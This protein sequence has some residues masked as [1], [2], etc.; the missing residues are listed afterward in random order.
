MVKKL[1]CIFIIFTLLYQDITYALTKSSSFHEKEFTHIYS[2]L[3]EVLL[4]IKNGNLQGLRKDGS[5]VWLDGGNFKIRFYEVGKATYTPHDDEDLIYED[6]IGGLRIEIYSKGLSQEDKDK[7]K[8]FL[9]NN[10]DIPLVARMVMEYIAGEK[11]LGSRIVRRSIEEETLSEFLSNNITID[12]DTIIR[13]VGIEPESDVRTAINDYL[14]IFRRR[15]ELKDKTLNAQ[16]VFLFR[17]LK[18]IEGEKIYKS[19]RKLLEL[20][21][22]KGRRIKLVSPDIMGWIVAKYEH[23]MPKDIDQQGLISFTWGDTIYINNN[24]RLCDLI[25]YILHEVVHLYGGKE[26]DARRVDRKIIAVLKGVVSLLRRIKVHDK[27]MKDLL[28]TIADVMEYELLGYELDLHTARLQ[29][30]VGGQAFLNHFHLSSINIIPYDES[31]I[32]AMTESVRG[33][34]RPERDPELFG[35]IENA[36]NRNNSEKI[37]MRLFWAFMKYIRRNL[38]E[39]QTPKEQTELIEP[40]YE[41]DILSYTITPEEAQRRL[42]EVVLNPNAPLFARINDAI[43]IDIFAESENLELGAVEKLLPVLQKEPIKALQILE[44]FRNRKSVELISS[45]LN[46]QDKKTRQMAAKCLFNIARALVSP[47]T[48][49]S[50]QTIK[51]MLDFINKPTIDIKDE[52]LNP[53]LQIVIVLSSIRCREAVPIF[54]DIIEKNKSKRIR[55]FVASALGSIGDTTI[56]SMIKERIWSK[57]DINSMWAT[58]TCIE[59]LPNDE[60]AE[61]IIET[62]FRTKNKGLTTHCLRALASVIKKRRISTKTVEPIIEE[63]MGVVTKHK[64]M[65]NLNFTLGRIA[66]IAIMEGKLEVFNNN[67][68]NKWLNYI[69]SNINGLI[70][71]ASGLIHDTLLNIDELKIHEDNPL[72]DVFN[73]ILNDLVGNWSELIRY[74]QRLRED[75]YRGKREYSDLIW[76]DIA[77]KFIHFSPNKEIYIGKLWFQRLCLEF[78]YRILL[79]TWDIGRIEDRDFIL[80]LMVLRTFFVPTQELPKGSIGA[81][82][83]VHGDYVV[84]DDKLFSD[85]LNI[86]GGVNTSWHEATHLLSAMGIADLSDI[87][88]LGASSHNYIEFY[89]LSEIFGLPDIEGIVDRLKN[90]EPIEEIVKDYIKIGLP[91]EYIYTIKALL[92]GMAVRDKSDSPGSAFF[93]VRNIKPEKV[94]KWNWEDVL[95]KLR[96]INNEIIDAYTIRGRQQILVHTY[97]DGARFSGYAMRLGV[98]TDFPEAVN[99]YI[100]LLVKHRLRPPQAEFVARLIA[101]FMKESSR[102]T[103]KIGKDIKDIPQGEINKWCRRFIIE[104]LKSLSI[105]M[106]NEIRLWSTYEEIEKLIERYLPDI[107]SQMTSHKIQ[108]E[109]KTLVLNAVK[110]NK[111]IFRAQKTGESK[112]TVFYITD[113]DGF[114]RP[115]SYT[116]ENGFFVIRVDF[117]KGEEI[118]SYIDPKNKK[119]RFINPE[120]KRIEID[121]ICRCLNIKLTKDNNMVIP[122][123]RYRKGISEVLKDLD[124]KKLKKYIIP[125][126][127]ISIVESIS[128]IT[129]YPEYGLVGIMGIIA[130]IIAFRFIKK[131]GILYEDTETRLTKQQRRKM[132]LSKAT[133]KEIRGFIKALSRGELL[134]RTGDVFLISDL[135]RLFL[136]HS[137]EDLVGILRK[138]FNL[139]KKAAS[140]IVNYIFKILEYKQEIT[141]MDLENMVIPKSIEN[142]IT[143]LADVL[144]FRPIFGEISLDTPIEKLARLKRVGLSECFRCAQGGRDSLY[145]LLKDSYKIGELRRLPDF[146]VEGV[147][148]ILFDI[149]LSSKDENDFIEKVIQLDITDYITPP[150]PR[151]RLIKE[152]RTKGKATLTPNENLMD[153]ILDTKGIYAGLE[154]LEELKKE[155]ED[156]DIYWTLSIYL[157]TFEVGPDAYIPVEVL[158]AWQSFRLWKGR[159][160]DIPYEECQK[161]FLQLYMQ[162]IYP[163]RDIR[164]FGWT[165]LW[166]SYF[167]KGSSIYNAVRELLKEISLRQDIDVNAIVQELRNKYKLNDQ[168]TK[169]LLYT[170]PIDGFIMLV[171]IY[172]KD[173]IWGK[174]G[175]RELEEILMRNINIVTEKDILDHE[176]FGNP[177]EWFHSFRNIGSELQEE[178]RKNVCTDVIRLIVDRLKEAGLTS[179]TREELEYLLEL[180]FTARLPTTNKRL[181]DVIS[182]IDVRKILFD[183]VKGRIGD[184]SRLKIIHFRKNQSI[185]TSLTKSTRQVW[186]ERYRGPDLEEFYSELR[187]AKTLLVFTHSH[188]ETVDLLNWLQKPMEENPSLQVRIIPQKSLWEPNSTRED[189]EYILRKRK[190]RFVILDNC[191]PGLGWLK[192]KEGV[193]VTKE[194]RKADLVL[195]IGWENLLSLQG[196]N[197]SCYFAVS[198]DNPLKGELTGYKT[199]DSVFLKTYSGIPACKIGTYRLS[200]Y[201]NA[202][203]SNNYRIL[204]SYFDGDKKQLH[205]WLKIEAKRR[206]K[207]PIEIILSDEYIK[208]P[209]HVFG[210]CAFRDIDP[211]ARESAIDILLRNYERFAIR[212]NPDSQDILS[213]ILV[214]KPSGDWYIFPDNKR[215]IIEW[216]KKR[217]LL[218]ILEEQEIKYLRIGDKVYRVTGNYINIEEVLKNPLFWLGNSQL[219]EYIGQENLYKYKDKQ[220]SPSGLSITDIPHSILIKIPQIKPDY[221]YDTAEDFFANPSEYLPLQLHYAMVLLGSPNIPQRVIGLEWIKKLLDSKDKE[222][223]EIIIQKGLLRSVDWLEKEIPYVDRDIF[224]LS[225]LTPKQE[226]LLRFLSGGYLIRPPLVKLPGQGV[227]SEFHDL[228]CKE[229]SGFDIELVQDDYAEGSGSVLFSSGERHYINPGDLLLDLSKDLLEGQMLGAVRLMKDGREIIQIPTNA[230][231]L[232]Y[233]KVVHHLGHIMATRFIEART[234]TANPLHEFIPTIEDVLVIKYLERLVKNLTD[235]FTNF[236]EEVDGANSQEEL[237]QVF[238]K[239]GLGYPQGKDP[240]GIKGEIKEI[241]NME[242][243]CSYIERNNLGT[244]TSSKEFLTILIDYLKGAVRDYIALLSENERIVLEGLLIAKSDTEINNLLII[245]SQLAG[246][247]IPK[248]NFDVDITWIVGLLTRSHMA[249][250][251]DRKGILERIDMVLKGQEPFSAKAVRI[252]GTVLYRMGIRVNAEER[253]DIEN[254]VLDILSGNWLQK[255][256]SALLERLSQ[257]EARGIN[258]EELRKKMNEVSSYMIGESQRLASVEP[259]EPKPVDIEIVNSWEAIPEY[260]E[261]HDIKR[262]FC[263]IDKTILDA[264][265]FITTT[266][267]FREMTKK[268]GLEET[269][270]EWRRLEEDLIVR[271]MLHPMEDCIP[272]IL[273]ELRQRGVEII[274][275]TARGKEDIPRTTRMLKTIGIE[276]FEI[277]TSKGGTPEEKRDAL[278][279]Y[280]KKKGWFKEKR[281]PSL[282][283]DDTLANLRA[284]CSDRRFSHIK[285]LWYRAPY[286]KRYEIAPE[287]FLENGDKAL[288]AGNIMEAL[289]WYYNAFYIMSRKDI[290][291]LLFDTV[292]EYVGFGPSIEELFYRFIKNRLSGYKS[293]LEKERVWQEKRKEEIPQLKE[294]KW[295]E[296][297]PDI[298]SPD[299]LEG[300]KRIIVIGSHPHGDHVKG[301]IDYAK[302]RLKNLV[303]TIRPMPGKLKTGGPITHS[304]SNY[305][306]RIGDE[307]IVLF[308][309][310]WFP[311]GFIDPLIQTIN[312]RDRE[313]LFIMDPD[314]ERTLDF[315]RQIQR[316]K[317]VG[318]KLHV[319]PYGEIMKTSIEKGQ[320]LEIENYPA[321]HLAPQVGSSIYIIRVLDANARKVIQ[322]IG[323]ISELGDIFPDRMSPEL[324]EK[325]ATLDRIIVDGTN[326]IAPMG[327]EPLPTQESPNKVHNYTRLVNRGKYLIAHL[328]TQ[329]IRMGEE[330]EIASQSLDPS[331]PIII[332][333]GKD[334][335][336]Q[337][338]RSYK[339]KKGEDY[340]YI[341][342]RKIYLV[343]DVVSF[344][345]RWAQNL[346]LLEE[347]LPERIKELRMSGWEEEEI[348]RFIDEWR[349]ADAQ[350][351][352]EYNGPSGKVKELERF[353]W[354]LRKTKAVVIS[355][356]QFRGDPKKRQ[357]QNFKGFQILDAI[358]DR[359]DVCI[360]IEGRLHLEEED[361]AIV[362]VLLDKK[363]NREIP[364]IT[365]TKPVKATIDNQWRSGHITFKQLINLLTRIADKAL[366]LGNVYN[367]R[368]YIPTPQIEWFSLIPEEDVKKYGRQLTDVIK[369]INRWNGR[370]EVSPEEMH[371]VKKV[372]KAIFEKD[373]F[374]TKFLGIKN[375]NS[376]RD[377]LIKRLDVIE[378]EARLNGRANNRIFVASTSR[379]IEVLKKITLVTDKG[380]IEIRQCLMDPQKLSELLMIAGRFIGF[381]IGISY[382]QGM[383]VDLVRK[384]KEEYSEDLMKELNREYLKELYEKTVKGEIPAHLQDLETQKGLD[385]YR[386]E[387]A[388]LLQKAKREADTDGKKLFGIWFG[389]LK[390]YIEA[391][392]LRIGIRSAKMI[393]PYTDLRIELSMLYD[394]VIE[395][396]YYYLQEDMG[397]KY[398]DITIVAGGDYAQMK[399][400]FKAPIR[401]GALIGPSQDPRYCTLLCKR[402]QGIL[403]KIGIQ[404]ELGEWDYF[405]NRRIIISGYKDAEVELK[406]PISKD[407]LVERKKRFVEDERILQEK[408]GFDVH[409]GPGGLDDIELIRYFFSTAL[410]P[411][412]NVLL[413]E[414]EEFLRRYREEAGLSS[415]GDKD[416]VKEFFTQIMV[417]LGFTGNKKDFKEEFF[418]RVAQVYK[419]LRR[420]MEGAMPKNISFGNIDEIEDIHKG[421][422]E[423][424]ER[425]GRLFT[426]DRLPY[427]LISFLRK[428]KEDYPA[429]GKRRFVI[430]QE[431]PSKPT[432]FYSEE[433]FGSVISHSGKRT[434]TIYIGLNALRLAYQNPEHRRGLTNIFLHENRDIER[435]YHM[436]LEEEV[437]NGIITNEDVDAIYLLWYDLITN[438]RFGVMYNLYLKRAK[439]NRY[440]EYFLDKIPADIRLT[441]GKELFRFRHGDALN[442]PDL[443]ELDIRLFQKGFST[444]TQVFILRHCTDRIRYERYKTIINDVKYLLSLPK[445]TRALILSELQGL[446]YT[447]FL[448]SLLKQEEKTRRAIIRERIG[449]E[450]KTYTS[451]DG[452]SIWYSVGGN[453]NTKRTLVFLHGIGVNSRDWRHQ[454]AFFEEHYRIITIDL[455]GFGKSEGL[456]TLPSHIKNYARDVEGI[457]TKEGIKDAILIGHSMGG[458]VAL[459]MDELYE[460][461]PSGERR[462]KGLVLINTVAGDPTR[463]FFSPRL[464]SIDI[465]QILNYILLYFSQF[466][467]IWNSPLYRK[468]VKIPVI[469]QSLQRLVEALIIQKETHPLYTEKVIKSVFMNDM[470]DLI[471]GFMAV[472]THNVEDRLDRLN[473]PVLWI[474]GGKDRI[475]LPQEQEED[476]KRL[477]DCKILKIPDAIHYPHATYPRLVNQAIYRFINNGL[478]RFTQ[479][480]SERFGQDITSELGMDLD[481]LRSRLIQKMPQPTNGDLEMISNISKIIASYGIETGVPQEVMMKAV[482]IIVTGIMEKRNRL[483][484]L[485]LPPPTPIFLKEEIDRISEEIAKSV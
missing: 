391:E 133:N 68:L 308:D 451:P 328:N 361:S 445:K 319:L 218:E 185:S 342:D 437:R 119:I 212:R 310:G 6:N 326:L 297:A 106:S 208:E 381:E 303:D 382:Q 484:D 340:F 392:F 108:E 478:N 73:I 353:F 88:L 8:V 426:E 294:I 188:S 334:S 81:T 30:T 102:L 179:P 407:I 205:D 45:F 12:T 359:K 211:E 22:D 351:I 189:I 431:E 333:G 387:L 453:K 199:G 309:L 281:V 25:F 446:E 398:K 298:T 373:E 355:S 164:R 72:E 385:K 315:N 289:E 237:R 282:Y 215:A 475:T 103:E 272:K 357:Y 75:I 52:D 327:E 217:L 2:N 183:Y 286:Q 450:F 329:S 79:D 299:F 74:M 370:K 267:W 461:T 139:S 92:E 428:I 34:I 113:S 44:E 172:Y 280:Y 343:H 314:T 483:K 5:G 406:K 209:I 165:F 169:Y 46:H 261:K 458:M 86:P 85:P 429:L 384:R 276:G 93:M 422:F 275:Y 59:N 466:D 100:E 356:S 145:K 173:V 9:L 21:I 122:T 58:V 262:I 221:I 270:K 64:D 291:N 335:I 389:K 50:P 442:L 479:L 134:L 95:W 156:E 425:E 421:V 257:L 427:E 197:R 39:K 63:L 424:A 354:D 454:I 109:I 98:E 232:N 463:S 364:T 432:M 301:F 317:S 174:E 480:V 278:V 245:A 84:L 259:P 180:I 277:I 352:T 410:T 15:L 430:I 254:R 66:S 263:D 300:I 170:T 337:L 455:R 54:L 191:S 423:K 447:A 441:K 414:T 274:L 247:Y 168:E 152:F 239:Y 17:R 210:E 49:S 161:K 380:P 226:R 279:N 11:I 158:D 292:A 415:G 378:E 223:R 240:Q 214:E 386:E 67:T 260:V 57:G 107:K 449:L 196:L 383:T 176:L 396:I 306:G 459:N 233:L 153:A 403:N 287:K 390:S 416:K 444:E 24:S 477:R 171:K 347:I 481:K 399:A 336:E 77:E 304:L 470:E 61:L 182:I 379:F 369:I 324:L 138:E 465:R 62:Y 96:K 224:H 167:E 194:L 120:E 313:I 121:E 284:V 472:M 155:V 460:D 186:S 36:I 394:A 371:F 193:I 3:Q 94:K 151:H 55:D 132:N 290:A 397:W 372:L 440:R 366:E 136:I 401:L 434:N 330:A 388:H 469:R 38:L 331:I 265:G 395:H 159:V 43:M 419:I 35:A 269:I 346:P 367:V 71:F 131:K 207:S 341:G 114:L 28:G 230:G 320:V 231:L 175:L 27:K 253:R 467:F 10:Q 227:S 1:F 256:N 246:C 147:V 60:S 244:F 105:K 48:F 251:A 250:C 14:T 462:I 33:V 408:E 204:L 222:I 420:V 358:V 149:Y 436:D 400:L 296:G 203:N 213:N 457:L 166:L 101:T 69:K 42:N 476:A 129:G 140:R 307:T 464:Q 452:A 130:T 255:L 124:L 195:G 83:A 116:E 235:G 322:S 160:G 187:Y 184:P 417:N 360:L 202:I 473:I 229:I 268:K 118:I 157:S 325:L 144:Y 192:E 323:Y 37:G 206:N 216:N 252:V 220:E 439:E 305:W 40:I 318:V 178:I 348:N 338:K 288:E 141:I 438:G 18:D 51:N 266:P 345:K 90:G 32:K 418:K 412:E 350:P 111:R 135:N 47:K 150:T 128:F 190:G 20:S 363:P 413:D 198:I 115:A 225:N 241:K 411:E 316:L 238:I 433:P 99:I 295:V 148:D 112:K 293:A 368:P 377:E 154:Y 264:E 339:V 302:R 249:N 56:I 162:Y 312:P 228:V 26:Q 110:G 143:G 285:G 89:L 404:V 405:P 393:A 78:S 471:Y 468:F 126:L 23:L 443:I 349:K 311:E 242:E 97:L 7:I 13:E 19:V 181:V 65:V 236:K 219:V 104:K 482:I 146:I 374:W 117:G 70:Y 127:L 485:D 4:S 321:Y 53:V 177:E 375:P 41:G 87:S 332:I 365:G 435:G 448:K 123:Q 402:L 16:D 82:E 29:I 80:E 409:T 76:K 344:H 362:R 163:R 376:I 243:F 456:G 125:V 234:R 283:I 474:I 258:T 31:Y 273:N 137:K 200:D 248:V 271:G 201:L 91:Q 142:V